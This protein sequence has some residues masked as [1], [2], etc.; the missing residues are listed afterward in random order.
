M[1]SIES[2]L[3]EIMLEHLQ[4]SSKNTK[5][6]VDVTKETVLAIKSVFDAD[7]D[8][9][10]AIALMFMALVGVLASPSPDTILRKLPALD[11]HHKDAL[12]ACASN[13]MAFVQLLTLV[14][15]VML[16]RQEANMVEAARVKHDILAH[17]SKKLD[18]QEGRGGTKKKEED[19]D[20]KEEKKEIP[21]KRINVL[22]RCAKERVKTMCEGTG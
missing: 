13:P 22:K 6:L 12:K 7:S 10:I 15:D 17:Y 20:E 2:M 8:D 4:P 16:F 21:K 3:G 18:C 5:V 11:K 19:D 14:V 9:A 1:E